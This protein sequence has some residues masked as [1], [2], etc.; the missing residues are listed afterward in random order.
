MFESPGT[1]RENTPH[2]PC[3]SPCEF[4]TFAKI[5]APYGGPT[6]EETFVRFGMTNLRFS[7]ALW[8]S[9]TEG[10]HQLDAATYESF[11]TNHPS[12]LQHTFTRPA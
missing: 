6:E 2:S 1:S 8:E 10:N 9:L 3:Q 11:V 7:R 5:W 12:P 4:V